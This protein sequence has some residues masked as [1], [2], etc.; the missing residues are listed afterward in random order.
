MDLLD[1]INFEP[2]TH[3]LWFVGDL[4][5]RG[6]ESLTALRFVRDLGEAAVTVL[7]NHDLHLLGTAAFGD[8]QLRKKDTLQPILEAH[9]STKLLGWLRRQPLL[10]HDDGLGYTLSHAGLPP[11]WDLGAAIQCT[12]E[13]QDVLSGDNH[14]DFLRDIYGNKP[15]HWNDKLAGIERW[16][17]TVNALTRMRYCDSDGRLALEQKGPPGT[18][19]SRLKP[20]FEIGKRRNSN[21]K[22]IFGHWSTL[23]LTGEDYHRYNVFPLDTGCLMGSHPRR[24]CDWRIRKNSACLPGSLR[25]TTESPVPAPAE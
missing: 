22:I 16:R 2:A 19:D 21:L 11:P 6:P 7:G 10:H 3:R 12:R 25:F 4:V 20:W 18:Q 8:A 23:R 1:T 17:Y 15:D 9:D 14:R 24:R 13:V 5:N